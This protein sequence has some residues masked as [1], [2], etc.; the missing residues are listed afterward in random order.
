MNGS[1][2]RSSPV[3]PRLREDHPQGDE[4]QHHAAGNG[5]SRSGDPQ[6]SQNVPPGEQ[7]QNQDDQGDQQF[8]NHY[9]DHPPGLDPGQGGQVERDVPDRVHHQKKQDC[10]GYQG[11]GGRTSRAQRCEAASY[12]ERS[13]GT[14]SGLDSGPDDPVRPR[15]GSAGERGRIRRWRKSPPARR[16]ACPSGRPRC[17]PGNRETRRPPSRRPEPRTTI[18]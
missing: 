2:S 9:P 4:E 5:Q 10:C 13:P 17:L 3:D 6:Q 7:E 12:P 18:R 14:S 16:P 8:P 11:H 1:P 15:S